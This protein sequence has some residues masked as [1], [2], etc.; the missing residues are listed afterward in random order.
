MLVTPEGFQALIDE[1]NGGIAGALAA[2]GAHIHAFAFRD[3]ELLIDPSHAPVSVAADPA[4][5][6]AVPC[7]VGRWQATTFAAIRVDRDF[8]PPSDTRWASLRSLFGLADDRWLAIAGRAQQLLEWERTHRFC[9][10]CGNPTERAAGERAMRCRVCSHSAYPRISPAMMCLVTRGHEILLARNANFPPGRFS[11]LAGFLEAGESVEDAIHR[12]VRE[13][14]GIE[15][16]NTRYFA[17]QSWPFPHSLMI[18]F[19]A[20]YAGGELLPNATEIVEA[21]W[22]RHDNL[23][24]LPPKVSIARALIDDTL[25]RL[26]R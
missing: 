11:A 3:N 20:E 25:S 14:V 16:K 13:E 4:F 17:S 2:N 22:Y 23:P 9:G 12:E 7:W 21:H 6:R 5:E 19:T 10:V 24:Q 18:A 26:A 8:D 1:A 15:V